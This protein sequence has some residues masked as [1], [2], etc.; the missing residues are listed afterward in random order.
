MKL[1]QLL[2]VP[3][4]ILWSWAITSGVAGAD[5]VIY[6]SA[7]VV[8]GQQGFV[9][10]FDITT[11]GSLTMTISNIPWLDV[12]TDL[13]SYLS[14]T[15]GVIGTTMYAASTESVNVEPGT[16]YAHWFGNAQGAYDEGV[17][18]VDIQFQPSYSTVPLPASLL[19]LLSGLGFLFLWP[20]R[21]PNL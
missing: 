10:P 15:S 1:R 19:S 16:F 17:L 11:P 21:G 5:T 7:S 20:A 8:E 9:E 2:S 18:G 14:T 12:V 13:T 4:L 6:D 3:F